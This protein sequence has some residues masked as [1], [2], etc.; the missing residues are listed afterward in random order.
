MCKPGC[1]ATLLAIGV[2]IVATLLCGSQNGKAQ[3]PIAV[4]LPP[5]GW[6]SW[7]SFSNMVDSQVI[8][9]QAKATISTGMHKSGYRYVNIDEGWWLGKR[10]AHG[11]IAVD[12]KAWPALAPGERDGDMSNIVRYIHSLGLKAGIYTDAGRDGCGTFYPDL[13]PS[14]QIGRA[15]V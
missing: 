4:P 7:N 12:P 3:K 6:S 8:V 13:G 10:D 14:Y 11:N 1:K 5:M 15:H 9:I 2:A